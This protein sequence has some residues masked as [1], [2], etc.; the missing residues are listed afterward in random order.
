MHEAGVRGIRLNL[1]LGVV[2]SINQLEGLASRIAPMQ[3]HLQLLAPP[4][5]LA[6]LGD[7]LHGLPVPVVFDHFGRIPPSMA[8]RHP[9]HEVVLNLLATGRAWIK[10]SGGYIVS[11]A[12]PPDYEDVTSLA[13]QYLQVAPERVLWGSDWPHASASAGHQAMPDDAHQMT[14]LARWTDDEVMLRRVLVDNPASLYRFAN[15]PKE[16]S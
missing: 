12:A 1:S 13:R 3:W 10:L 14:L 7:R 8:N 15:C 4:D 2:S 5:V 11:Q 6:Q 9:A 16:T